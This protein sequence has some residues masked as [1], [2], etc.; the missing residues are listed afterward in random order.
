MSDTERRSSPR[1]V[2]TFPVS[3]MT[4]ATHLDG[5]LMDISAHGTLLHAIGRINVRCRIEGSEYR[6]SLV[7]AHPLDDGTIA[8]AIE[9]VLESDE[10]GDRDDAPQ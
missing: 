10:S 9:D 4:D 7:R 1:S 5:E 2:V 3:V 8:Y 6:G